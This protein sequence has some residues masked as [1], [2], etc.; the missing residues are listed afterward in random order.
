M[1]SRVPISDLLV[2]LQG[3][4]GQKAS[5]RN[6]A[7]WTELYRRVPDRHDV[8]INYVL[9]LWN[10]EAV[11]HLVKLLPE[12]VKRF[13]ESEPIHAFWTEFPLT[14][15]NPLNA[16]P[17]MEVMLAKF[18][19]KPE[20]SFRAYQIYLSLGKFEAARQVAMQAFEKFGVDEFRSL[21]LIAEKYEQVK[22]EWA[23]ASAQRDYHIFCIGLDRQPRRFQRVQ[24]QLQRMGETVHRIS[25]VDGRTLPDMASRALTQSA[26][27]RMKGTLGCFLS[28]VRVWEICVQSDRP[29]AFVTEDDTSFIL[30]PPPSTAFL[31]TGE[32]KFDLCF[33]NERTQNA[34]FLPKGMS[35]DMALPLESILVNKVD[36]FRG[37]GTDGY[38]VSRQGAQKLL[39]MVAED[40]L[41]G[42]VDWRLMLYAAGEGD[43][44]TTPNEFIADTLKMHRDHRKSTG[45]LKALVAAPAIVKVYNGGSV[46]EW[47]ND[48]GHAHEEAVA[49]P[50]P[51]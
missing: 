12:L 9:Q 47:M 17:R 37:I 24:A 33:V 3:P 8:A 16:E 50:P 26:S 21:T 13:P 5:A 18:P 4:D 30:P 39:D 51:A 41:V 44:N 45:R 11:D 1:F 7:L 27:S 34:A 29:Y 46:R 2:M 38:F 14:W 25:G 19:S 23:G 22:A 6:R 28:H 35:L 40:G 42:D 10:A 36:G 31:N 32:R 43:I 20:L 48:F 49:S 15:G